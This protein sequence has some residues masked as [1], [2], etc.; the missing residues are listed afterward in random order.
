MSSLF[1]GVLKLKKGISLRA[2]DWSLVAFIASIAL[3]AFL[4]GALVVQWHLPPSEQ[5]RN[6]ARAFE[7]VSGM[8]DEVFLNSLNKIDRS[9]RARPEFAKLDKSAGK[10]LLLVTG[11]P[12][13]D[14]KR[15]PKFGCLAWI[16]D[17]QGHVLHAWPLPL[18]AL[19]KNAKGFKGNVN[20]R[21][22]YPVGLGMLRDGSLVATFHAR[23]TYPYVAGIARISWTGEVV[24]QHVDGAHHWLHI[25]D[26]GLIYAPYQERRSPDFLSK[27]AVN[28]RCEHESYDEGIRI[29]RQNGEVVRTILLTETFLRDGYPGL[30]YSVRDDCDPIHLNSVDV[31]TEEVASRIPGANAGDLLVSVRELSAIIMLDPQTGQI[32]HMING[33]TAAQHSAHFLKDGSVIAFDNQGG[34]R[35]RGGSRILRIDM[36]TGRYS[37]IFPQAQSESILPFSSEDGGTVSPSPDSSR[38]IVSS[39]DGSRSFE[40]DIATG[41]PL[42]LMKQVFDVA[43]F[44]KEDR[45]V[46]G[47]F[48]PYGVYYLTEDQLSDLSF[49]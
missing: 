9:A 24:W 43:P 45:P 41:K 8:E 36:G 5:L 11:G 27:Y 14:A 26:D 28:H 2:I 46:A 37:T 42:W 32:K 16:F 25:G 31:A 44:L 29:Y 33:R 17:R 40:I 12:N 23:N 21:N 34:M 49:E 6:A 35:F 15:C 4:A 18:D 7:A 39:K 38:A 20:P 1:D 47:Y 22:F 13:Q 3:F 19:F 48:K 10:E 30:L